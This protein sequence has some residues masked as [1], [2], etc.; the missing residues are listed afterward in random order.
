MGWMRNILMVVGLLAIIA[1]FL[2]AQTK[3]P[4]A[5]FKDSLTM[6]LS[7]LGTPIS[8]QSKTTV[9]QSKGQQGEI[10]FSDRPD[11]L[12]HTETRVIDTRKGTTIDMAEP[13]KID[14]SPPNSLSWS[15]DKERFQRQAAALQQARMDRAI[16]GQE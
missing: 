2:P 4:I 13:I 5:S 12:N 1:Y 15:E 9:Y 8:T 16:Y 14:Q 11:N 10:K 3:Q 7:K 6:D